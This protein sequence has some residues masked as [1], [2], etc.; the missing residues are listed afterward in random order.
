MLGIEKEMLTSKAVME[1]LASVDHHLVDDKCASLMFS[2]NK[3]LSIN[4][5][6][7]THPAKF[8]LQHFKLCDF[9]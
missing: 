1:N 3:P 6:G 9:F 4:C 5:D 7:S 2:K 8:V